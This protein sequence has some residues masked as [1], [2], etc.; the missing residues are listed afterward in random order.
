MLEI[1]NLCFSYGE[2]EILKDINLRVKKG[3]RVILLGGSGSGKSTLLHLIAGFIAPSQGTIMIEG[4]VASSKDTIDMPPHK[5]GISMIFQDL[6]LWPHMSVGENIEFGLKMQKM[7]KK[8]RDT[9]V[10]EYL[11][12]VDLE[13]FENRAISQLSGGQMQRVAIARSL[14]TSPKIL[15][16][17]EPL[18]SLDEDL[19]K[20]LREMI[21]TLQSTLGFALIYVTHNQA[22]AREVATRTISLKETKIA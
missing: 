17:D 10:E 22:E 9:K 13:G 3:E 14:I 16:L 2:N 18:S 7:P 5:R 11:K 6:A 1:K 4:K 21:V 20:R 12:L 8:Q 19:N 15:L